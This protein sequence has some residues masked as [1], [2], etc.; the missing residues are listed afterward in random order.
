[1]AKKLTWAQQQRMD[2]IMETISIFGFINRE[3][4][5]KKFWVST[6]QASADIYLFM[7]R[8]PKTIVYD[9]STKRYVRVEK[10]GKR[11]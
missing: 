10:K 11:K 8:H 4:V 2:W 7:H 1:V 3:H 5:A 6:P 9:N